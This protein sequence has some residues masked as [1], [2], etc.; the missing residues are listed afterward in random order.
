V[1]EVIILAVAL[2]MDAFAVSIGLGSKH[3]KQTKSLALMS[4]IY[5]GLFQGLMPL[6]GYMG[7]KGILG[8]VEEYAQWV[9]FAL[10]ILIGGKMIYESITEGIEEDIVKITH[11]VMLILAIATS[12]DAMA[13]GFT[14]TLIEI[15]PFLACAIIGVATLFFSWMGVFI[16][17]K[18]GTW[19]ESKAELLGGIVLILIGFKVLLF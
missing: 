7:G 5:F 17:A 11:K 2:S 13:A 19:L 18:S 15:N 16:G 9:A 3:V 8:W 10:L 1:F 6:I 14:L 4:G 12:V